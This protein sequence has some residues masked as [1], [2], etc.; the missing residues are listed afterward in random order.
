DGRWET[1]GG[2]VLAVVAT[3]STR[4]SAVAAA[5]AAADRIRFDGLQ[6]RRDI[7][8]LHFDSVNP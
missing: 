7:G 5:H 3:G 2:R 6:R 1:C 8:I 4:D